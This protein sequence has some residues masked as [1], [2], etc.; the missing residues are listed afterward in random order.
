MKQL[1]IFEAKAKELYP[2][3]SPEFKAML[4][5]SFGTD[6]FKEKI[7]D[8]VKTY[9]DALVV[10]AIRNPV[11][12]TDTPDEAAY[13]K[14]KVIIQALNEGWKPNWDNSDEYKWFP[15]FDMRN[16]FSFYDVD[17][18]SSASYV[19]SRLCFKSR[20]LAIYAAN[21]FLDIY[22]AFHQ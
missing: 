20:E 3:A 6:F 13:K 8:R 16:G 1:Q 2:S 22:K 14:L 9:E 4:N 7:T 15:V 5:E 10:I 18:W 19:G 17:R 12:S 11:N 21:Q